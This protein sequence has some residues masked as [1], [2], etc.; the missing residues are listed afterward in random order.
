MSDTAN[1]V[2]GSDA[3]MQARLGRV[4][5]SRIADVVAKAK[6][7][8]GWGESRRK[9]RKQ[10]AIERRKKKPLSGLYKNAIMDRGNEVEPQAREEYIKA[11]FND[12]TEVGFVPHPRIDMSGAS[13]DGLVAPDGIIQIKCPLDEAHYETLKN[14]KID[15]GYIKQIQWEMACTER[16]WA[17]YVSF[18]PEWEEE[19]DRLKIIR[20][21]RDDEMIAELEKQVVIFL[22]E[23]DEEVKQYGMKIAA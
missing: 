9:Y 14:D 13:P 2:Q 21:D 19:E 15:G 10:L 17:D 16:N 12:V 3:W 5:A 18:N 22:K 11:T 8:N 1:L 4:T 6:T 7:G 23:V 20:V